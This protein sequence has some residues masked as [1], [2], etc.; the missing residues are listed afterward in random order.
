MKNF[1]KTTLIFAIA[2]F[3]FTTCGD[4]GDLSNPGG[5]QGGNGGNGGN[6]NNSKETIW[7][8]KNADGWSFT[9]GTINNQPAAISHTDNKGLPAGGTTLRKK[10][11]KIVYARARPVV[12]YEDMGGIFLGG[13]DNES[14]VRLLIGGRNG[15]SSPSNWDTTAWSQEGPNNYYDG[16]GEE[17]F[18]DLIDLSTRPV[19]ITVTVSGYVSYMARALLIIRVNNSSGTNGLSP[20]GEAS[21]I[22]QLSGPDG[23]TGQKIS[24]LEKNNNGHWVWT[25][26][27]HPDMIDYHPN[28]PSGPNPGKETLKKAYF[29]FQ[30][31]A[32]GTSSGGNDNHIV[33]SSIKIEYDDTI[34]YTP[35]S[36]E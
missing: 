7:E 36:G 10:N 11:G 20:L 23:T 25:V 21:R 8:W 13:R 29:A 19:R 34:T 30:T 15:G 9:T 18:E 2:A 6:G 14:V 1:L 32:A 24:D 35:P 17:W 28:D 5:N 3:L 33:I 31:Q 26:E 22:G 27:F 16:E 4:D 12:W